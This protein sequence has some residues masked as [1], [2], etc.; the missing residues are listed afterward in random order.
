MKKEENSYKSSVRKWLKFHTFKTLVRRESLLISLI[1][2]LSFV[3]LEEYQAFLK[4]PG[5]FDKVKIF[6]MWEENNTLRATEI[7]LLNKDAIYKIGFS[8]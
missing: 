6:F 4:Q 2:I 5:D 8:K 7:L 1:L 3:C